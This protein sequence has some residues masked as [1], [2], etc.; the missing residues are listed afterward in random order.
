MSDIT[1]ARDVEAADLKSMG[2]MDIDNV[3][4]L[5]DVQLRD[6]PTARD[7]YKR[8]EKQNWSVYDIE[9]TKDIADWA[10]LPDEIK[11]QLVGA[12]YAF[13]LGE[14]A[15]TDTL[16]PM[17]HAAPTDEDRQFLSTQLVDEARH[18][19][20]F[21]RFFR[22]VLGVDGLD[23]ARQEPEV[24]DY[25]FTMDERGY[26]RL[27]YKHLRE[28]TDA[29]R[30]DP[31][32]YGKW[33]DSICLYHMVIEGM[34]ALFGQRFILQAARAFDI[35]PGFR[36][37]FTAVTRDESRH[38]NYAVYA[39]RMAV[40]AGH[41]D[42]IVDSV[43]KYMEDGCAV[44]TRNNDEIPLATPEAQAMVPEALQQGSFADQWSFPAMQLRKRLRQAGISPAG[45]DRLESEWWDH[46]DRNVAE[47]EQVVGKPHPAMNEPDWATRRE[48]QTVDA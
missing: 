46:V 3:Y 35:L 29:V 43:S 8:W 15:V 33:I 13:F 48:R 5:M 28:V 40:E 37:G 1:I 47:Y 36:A 17:V 39:L 41:H 30:M 10:V 25:L 22:E 24:Q 21:D 27:F 31:G 42:R 20:F 32:D 23:A 44:L 7:L 14:A 6:R 34:L 16:S 19:I 38:V 4:V 12:L 9:F 18:T 45:L 11:A 2:N 26:G